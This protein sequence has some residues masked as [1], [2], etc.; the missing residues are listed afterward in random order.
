MERKS[1]G[2]KADEFR[3][4]GQIWDE[5]NQRADHKAGKIKYKSKKNI[6]YTNHT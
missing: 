5:L 3:S 4:G 6:T 2:R 1:E